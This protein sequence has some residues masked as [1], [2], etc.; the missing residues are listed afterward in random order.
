MDV[1]TA[2]LNGNLEE[3]I[4]M[5]QPEG[6]VADRKGNMVCKLQKSIYRLK[7]TSR[8]WNIRFDQI[9]KSFGFIQNLDEPCVYKKCE[10]KV[11]SFLVLYVDDILLIG[12]D[13][14]TLST[15]KVWLP[16]SFDMKDLGEASYIIGIK[17]IR[18]RK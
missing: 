9:V 16:S 12:N 4:Y 18:D 8:S 15:V 1:K 2:F 7:Q 13:V 14:V 17:L 11:V 6:F 5:Q 10:G 3:D